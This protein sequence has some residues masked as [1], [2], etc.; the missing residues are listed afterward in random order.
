MIDR[1]S[2]ATGRLGPVDDADAMAANIMDVLCSNHETMA[3]AARAHALQ[4]SWVSSMDTLFGQ[5]YPA[6]FEWRRE[7]Q[8]ARVIAPALAA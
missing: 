3:A 5:V 8:T 7:Q 2:M 4:F 1:V 6:A